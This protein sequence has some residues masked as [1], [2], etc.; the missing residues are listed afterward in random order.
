M[1]AFDVYTGRSV[2]S[3]VW[4]WMSI[5][6]DWDMEAYRAMEAG[7]TVFLVGFALGGAVRRKALYIVEGQGA[8]WDTLQHLRTIAG[9]P[10][11]VADAD[12]S[13]SMRELAGL[14]GPVLTT[15]DPAVVSGLDLL[16][17][18]DIAAHRPPLIPGITESRSMRQALDAATP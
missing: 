17:A 9:R 5:D 12:A 10:T 15:T 8:M 11:E 6:A 7:F 2:A 4:P 13:W 18:L 3:P 14:V 16:H 1:S